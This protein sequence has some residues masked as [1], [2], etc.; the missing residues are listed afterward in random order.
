MLTQA[1]HGAVLL[2]APQRVELPRREWRVIHT[3]S[4][5]EK[6]L[7]EFLEAR[8]IE[9]YLPLVKRVRYYGRRKKVARLPLFP[10]YLFLRGEAEDVYL[11]DRTDRVVQV[12]GVADQDALEADLAAIRFAL[13]R[14]GG[15]EPTPCPAAGI[16]VEVT[17]GPFR[18]LR[19]IVDRGAQDDR[20]VLGVRMLGRAADLEIDRTLLRPIVD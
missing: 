6:A 16:W 14:N 20:L 2:G 13:E 19:G 15:L 1:N 11:A 4:R 8:G 5:Q 7:G 18:G 3:R 17:G 10:G 9:H 12:I